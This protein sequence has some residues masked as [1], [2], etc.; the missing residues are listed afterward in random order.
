MGLNP[1]RDQRK[2]AADVVMVLL[3][4]AVTIGVILWAVM[5]G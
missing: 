1:F 3:A 2:S 5:G 4:I